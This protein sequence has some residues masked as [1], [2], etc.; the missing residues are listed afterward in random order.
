MINTNKPTLH[1][2]TNAKWFRMIQKG[3]KTV[4]YREIKHH[5]G[6]LFSCGQIR[7]NG[8]YYQDYEVNICFHLSTSK[9]HATMLL[10]CEGL[11][12][13]IGKPEWGAVLNVPYYR[14]CLG[15]ILAVRKYKL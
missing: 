15:K 5:Y 10:E 13:G 12:I 11:S 14:L 8:M 9:Y 1:L 3:I 4:D 2:V 6:R 7:I